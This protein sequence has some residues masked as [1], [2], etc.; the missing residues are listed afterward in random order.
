MPHDGSR[1]NEELPLVIVLTSLP[2]PIFD[3]HFRFFLRLLSKR[4]VLYTEMITAPTLYHNKDSRDRFLKF[5]AP[6]EHPVVLQLGGSDPF[7]LSEASRIALPYNYDAINLNCGCPSERVSGRGCFGA[8]LMREP[9][10]VA[11]ICTAMGE[12]SEGRIPITVKC[13]IGV[14]D[15]DSYEQLAEFVRRVSCASPV[16]HFVVH[17]RKAILGGLSPDQNRRVP[18]LKYPF[19][20]RLCKEFPHLRFTLNGGVLSYEDVET[21]LKE[22]VHGVMVGRAIIARPFYWSDIDA[23]LYGAVGENPGLTRGEILHQYGAY[24]EEE[25]VREGGRLRRLLTKPVHHLFA[26]E[27]MGKR[28]RAALDQALLDPTLG[29]RQVLETATAVL[30]PALLEVKPGSPSIPA[31]ETVRH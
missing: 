21:H 28:F 19:V 29:V 12:G 24:A 16:R 9:E 20:Y 8:A 10:R 14:D 26:G 5:N 23:R 6:A 27:P 3:R 18:P 15:E 11:D 2:L 22:G 13:R 17:A 31:P 1:R 30:P 25:D 4:M 7:L